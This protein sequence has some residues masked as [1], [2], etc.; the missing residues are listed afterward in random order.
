[1]SYTILYNK[2]FVKVADD[3]FIPMVQIGDNNVYESDRKRARS[4]YNQR[5]VTGGRIWASSGEILSTIDRIREERIASNKRTIE[6]GYLNEQD[7]YD[8]KRFGWHEGIAIYGKHTSN[9]TFGMFRNFYKAGIERALTVEK[10]VESGVCLHMKVYYYRPEDITSKGKEIRNDVLF[11]TTEQLVSTI[12][13]WVEYYGE[14][15][16]RIH[17]YYRDSWTLDELTKSMGKKVKRQRQWVESRTYYVLEG[18]NGGNGYFLKGTSKGYRYSYTSTGAKKFLT[19]KAAKQFHKR[20][21]NKDLFQV[22][23]CEH[24][25][26][27]SVP[28]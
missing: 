24:P 4:W 12:N 7:N 20:M 18:I 2:Q 27:V 13:E 1:M 23:L 10:L 17:L 8:D 21:K 14:L 16:D 26:T 28:A 6:S 11:T 5:Y 9:T 22:R 19:E 3:L 25:Y 15:A